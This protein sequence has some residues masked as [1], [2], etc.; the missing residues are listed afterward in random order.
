LA[1]A[2]YQRTQEGKQLSQTLKLILKTPKPLG[3]K[4]TL[5]Q[6]PKDFVAVLPKRSTPDNAAC[7]DFFF[8]VARRAFLTTP[9]VTAKP[10]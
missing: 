7:Q 3:K 2:G 8:W 4:L 6:N 1:N 5:N 10:M 9:V